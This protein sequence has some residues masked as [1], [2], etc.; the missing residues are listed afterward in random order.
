MPDTYRTLC[1]PAVIH[2]I[3]EQSYAPAAISECIER[4]TAARDAH[5]LVAEDDDTVVGFLHYDCEGPRPELHRLY[6]EPGRKRKGIGSLLVEELH[7]RLEP[8]AS[9]VLMVVADNRPAVAFYSRHGF[10]EE[11]QVD[12]VDYMREHMEVEFPAGTPPVPALLLSFTAGD[13]PYDPPVTD[14]RGA[15][16]DP[17]HG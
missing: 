11:A 15:I 14:S 16:R 17:V 12:G 4:C 10:Q 8:Q 1:D 3:V 2:S 9:Y 6:V 5:F 7:R 13:E